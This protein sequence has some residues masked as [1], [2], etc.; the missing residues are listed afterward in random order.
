MTLSEPKRLHSASLFFAVYPL[1]RSF[2]IPALLF[3]LFAEG[4]R[5]QIWLSLLIIPTFV[6]QAYR[7][8][9][10]RYH[11]R[12]D[13]LV[14]T[15]GYWL[16]TERHIPYDRIQNIDLVQDPVQRMC[17]VGQVSIETASGAEAEASLKVLSLSAVSE[18]REAIRERQ[19]AAARL[20]TSD[21]EVSSEEQA[22]LEEQIGPMPLQAEAKPL[23][24]LSTGELLRL[25]VDPGRSLAPVAVLLGVSWEFDLF[26]RYAVRDR[27]QEWQDAGGFGYGWIDGVLVGLAVVLALTLF[28]IVGTF[29]VFSAFRLELRD[30]QF[31]LRRGLL[32]RV[33]ATIPRK[34]VQIVTV[35]ESLLHRWMSR[36]KL[37]IGTAGSFSEDDTPKEASW[38]A[39]LLPQARVQ[40]FLQQIDARLDLSKADW[41]APSRD[42]L[43]RARRIAVLLGLFWWLLLSLVMIGDEAHVA[44]LLVTPMPMAYLWWR[45]TCKHRRRNWT[46]TADFVA[47][48][49]GFLNVR[50]TLVLFEKLQSCAVHHGP[51][52]RRW[53]MA[54]LSL[55][56]AGG[57]QTGHRVVIPHLP[58]DLAAALDEELVRRAQSARFHWG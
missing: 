9:T 40:E 6:Y 16:R 45:A 5:W 21:D 46:M 2:L 32:T 52:D 1:L 53:R 56:T 44:W 13:E 14:V 20:S 28:S 30:E 18:L 22:S 55:D 50:T 36:A 19:A 29:L 12:E 11:C 48:R 10:L 15:V 8:Y 17:S 26:E 7:I 33:R 23:L 34:R 24:E 3:Y 4:D 39:P 49:S 37:R 25:A 38:L 58:L 31:R 27:L 54:R 43:R 35:H 51:L 57:G 47:F 42:S 41:R